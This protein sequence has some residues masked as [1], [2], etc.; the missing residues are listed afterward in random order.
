MAS[1]QIRGLGIAIATLVA[2]VALA[3]A[4]GAASP[5]KPHA[6]AAPAAGH[7]PRAR[8]GARSLRQFGNDFAPRVVAAGTVFGDGGV[9]GFEPAITKAPNG[10]LLT[11]FPTTSDAEPGGELR[12]SR[13]TDGG[14]TWGPSTTL[15]S[16]RVFPGGSMVVELGMTTLRDGTILLPFAEGVNYTQYNHRD[17]RIYVARSTDNGH[18]WSGL[19]TPVTLPVATQE[20]WP[21]GKLIQLRDGSVL[22]PIW[23]TRTLRPDWEKNPMIWEAAVVRSFDGGRTWQRYSTIAFDPH[24]PPTSWF[25]PPTL[26]PGGGTETTIEQLRDGRLAAHVRFE[27]PTGAPDLKINQEVS[28]DTLSYSSDDGATWTRPVITTMPASSPSMETAPCSSSLPRGI[29]KTLLGYRDASLPAGLQTAT[30][31]ASFDGGVT[32]FGKTVLEEPD[33]APIG[34]FQSAYPAFQR[35]DATHLIVVFMVYTNGG[36]WRVGYNILEDADR[37]ECRDQADVA[38]SYTR[39]YPTLFFMRHDADEWPYAYARRER[40]FSRTTR[41]RDVARR[42]APQVSCQASEPKLTLDR[43]PRRSLD[44]MATLSDA[45]IR[46]GDVLLVQGA[47]GTAGVRRGFADLDLYPDDRH[48]YGWDDACDAALPVDYQA[49][50]VGLHVRIPPDKA[51]TSIRLRDTDGMSR[52]TRDDYTLWTS[53]DNKTYTAVPDWQFAETQD[54]AGRLVHTF[55]GMSITAPYIKVHQDTNDQS[56]TFV[57]GSLRNDLTDTFGPRG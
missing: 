44:P 52:L 8:A 40:S 10:D 24:T 45:R 56:P 7:I 27:T 18:T 9:A 37:S 35:L 1:L 41:L 50:S 32:W 48:L 55:S 26:Y 42:V 54:P 17:S 28:V 53:T 2:S 31:S 29:T 38:T 4:A 36:N 20:M 21:Y 51:V 33:H 46:D 34:T 5:P 19:D 39:R 57:L 30:V 25:G 14:L 16:P 13:S 3:P 6:A 43:A 15:A 49:R 47:P 22:M 11:A 23:G 12:L